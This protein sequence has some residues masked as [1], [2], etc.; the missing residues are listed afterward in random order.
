M[1]KIGIFTFH[2]GTNYGGVL[3]AY[4]LQ[5]VLQSLGYKVEIVNYYPITHRNSFLRCL[6]R[7]FVSRFQEYQKE[8]LFVPFRKKN[9]NLTPAYHD[10]ERL[11]KACTDFDV[12]IVGSDQ[13]WNP[14]IALTYGKAYYL[15][16]AHQN[17]KKISYAASLGCSDYPSEVLNQILPSIML[18]DS[19]SVRE[20]SA[21][22]ILENAGVSNVALTPDPT[23]LVNPEVFRSF[24]KKPSV[25]DHAFFYLLHA[26]HRFFRRVESHISKKHLVLRAK[27]GKSALTIEEWLSSL[28]FSRVVITNSFHGVVFSLLFHKNFVVFPVKGKLQGM[29]D[30]IVTLLSQ[31]GLEKKVLMSYDDTDALDSCLN[32]VV[33]WKRVDNQIHALRMKGVDFLKHS[34]GCD[35]SC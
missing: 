12:L 22:T 28:W 30:R 23:I 26:D 35:E 3:Q 4:S 34:I 33:D 15:G 18:F 6:G 25:T 8:G 7:S 2:W 1:K 32:I 31:V 10:Y 11:E 19:V 17:I 9:L 14:F 13:I 5:T 21:V 27:N 16:F 20:H 24:I 29:N